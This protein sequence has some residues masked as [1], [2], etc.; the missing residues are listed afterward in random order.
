M[1]KIL[2]GEDS[3]PKTTLNIQ[4]DQKVSVHLMITIHL[5]TWLNLLGSRPPGPGGH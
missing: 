3:W 5:A 2:I 4:S 1:K